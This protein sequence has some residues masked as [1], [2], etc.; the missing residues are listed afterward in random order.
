MIQFF[1]LCHVVFLFV[2]LV[3]VKAASQSDLKHNFAA[4]QHR[5]G[6]MSR[7]QTQNSDNT[8]LTAERQSN[9]INLCTW[10]PSGCPACPPEPVCRHRWRQSDASAAPGTAQPQTASRR[11]NT[12]R[13]SIN[14]CVQSLHIITKCSYFRSVLLTKD[15]DGRGP[16]SHLLVLGT[17]DL[18]HGLGCWMLDLNLLP[19]RDISWSKQWLVSLTDSV[20]VFLTSR[21][22]AFPSLVITIPPVGSSNICPQMAHW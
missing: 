18:Y 7:Y 20:V 15:D 9:C 19:W 6:L 17:T 1:H 11:L 16:V 4:Q 10:S 2:T 3:E 12:D 8:S 14:T 13:L 22:M 21:R 5:S